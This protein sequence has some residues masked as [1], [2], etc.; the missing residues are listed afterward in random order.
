LIQYNFISA[1]SAN[2]NASEPF[3]DLLDASCGTGAMLGMFK[4][5]C[6][7]KN[8]T[9]IDFSEKMIETAKKKHLEGVWF[10]TGTARHC[11]FPTTVLIS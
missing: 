6:P 10:V 3:T 7:D 1:F 9:G 11:H 5:D 4:R 2:I 8:Y